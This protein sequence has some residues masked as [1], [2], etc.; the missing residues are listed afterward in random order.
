MQI[1]SYLSKIA[2]S[3]SILAWDGYKIAASKGILHNPEKNETTVGGSLFVEKPIKA[4]D[5]SPYVSAGTGVSI[6][7]TEGG[8][9]KIN[10][11]P[12]IW[13]WNEED[14]SQF[15][16]SCDTIGTGSLSAV[17]TS[18][19]KAIRVEF[20]EKIEDGIFVFS[21]NDL[22]IPIDNKNRVRYSLKFRL[23]NFSGQPKEWF[24]IGTTFLSNTENSEKYYGLGSLCSFSTQNIKIFKVEA[25]LVSI[26][27]YF[28]NGPRIQ[29]GSQYGKPNNLIEFN[30]V[31][32]KNRKAY[33]FQ[34]NWNVTNS[35]TAINSG[36]SVDDNYY[37][38]EFGNFKETWGQQTLN[39]CGIAIMAAPG[40]KPASFEI[41]CLEILKHPMDW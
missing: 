32:L 39:S 21:I 6:A 24:G 11:S 20:K 26:G 2:S 14:V 13:K 12:V 27:R 34:N 10:A 1:F 22:N 36:T 17:D 23:T 5:G 18:C 8:G 33:G 40:H 25:G 41:D 28:P 37:S 30:V 3:G 29:L 4:S 16:I 38:L 15:S 19:G 31:A 9:I 35:A 7:E